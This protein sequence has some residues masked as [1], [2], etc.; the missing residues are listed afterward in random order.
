MTTKTQDGLCGSIA[1]PRDSHSWQQHL[2]PSPSSN[3]LRVNMLLYVANRRD[4]S[5]AR[6]AGHGE[7]PGD[8]SSL[9]SAPPGDPVRATPPGR[10]STGWQSQYHAAHLAAD[11][12]CSSSYLSSHHHPPP[13]H[14]PSSSPLVCVSVCFSVCNFMICCCA[15]RRRS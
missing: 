10:H 3:T 12:S 13:F 9:C 7:C 11:V 15:S 6:A 4:N 14:L 2:C 1:K 5:V 8:G